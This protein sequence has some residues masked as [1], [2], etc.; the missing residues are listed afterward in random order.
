MPMLQS[1]SALAGVSPFSLT[2][3][4]IGFEDRFPRGA[5]QIGI[6]AHQEV[7]RRRSR[8]GARRSSCP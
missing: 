2:R 4:S 5:I 3:K 8:R 6:D 1:D 7:L